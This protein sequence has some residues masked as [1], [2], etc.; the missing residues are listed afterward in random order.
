MDKDLP[1]DIEENRDNNRYAKTS[2]RYDEDCSR[3]QHNDH[4]N[5]GGHSESQYQQSGHKYNKHCRD[6]RR[7]KI[8]SSK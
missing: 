6:I 3:G 5:R 7:L 4:R 2:Q 1:Q 8:P